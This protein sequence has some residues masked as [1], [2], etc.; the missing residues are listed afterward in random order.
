MA[1]AAKT[2]RKKGSSQAEQRVRKGRH[3]PQ[4]ER[5]LKTYWPYLPL[6]AI[7]GIGLLFSNLWGVVQTNVLGY[8]TDTS[9]NGL[10]QYTNNER[11]AN[12]IGA[13]ALN[14]TL[15]AAAQA[16]ANDMVARDYWSHY[17][18]DGNPPW[19]FFSNAGYSYV[20]AGENL[21]YG[22]DNS[23]TT[24]VAWMNS[25][26]HRANILNNSFVDVGFGIANSPN[27]QGTGPETIVVAMYGSTVAG[28]TAPPANAPVAKAPAPAPVPAP[29]PEPSPVAA[30]PT[31][32]P[33]PTPT[34]TP[35]AEPNTTTAIPAPATSAPAPV[36]ARKVARVQLLAS[37]E[38]SWSMFAVSAIATISIAIFFLRHGL[39]WHRVLVKGEAF[40]HKHPFLDVAL[41]GL[42]MVGYVLTRTAGIIR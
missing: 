8:A 23:N 34:P 25:P 5:Y 15:N 9:I 20:T 16:K 29:V 26:G 10:L 3:H 6:V 38:A 13:L 33:T 27:Y 21:A 32:Q 24:V 30:E 35:A 39:L 31:P 7:V 36:A 11:A 22:F 1:L 37:N 12:S 42:A 18:P 14:S 4:D 40:V 17:T 28:A 41:V 2:K 19:V